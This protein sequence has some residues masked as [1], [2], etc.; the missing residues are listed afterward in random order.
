MILSIIV[1]TN[2]SFA[3]FL[4]QSVGQMIGELLKQL[5]E[6]RF[7]VKASHGPRY[8]VGCRKKVGINC[9]DVA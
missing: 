3:M 5:D 9:S 8:V 4:L 6:D 1:G 2:E 7:I